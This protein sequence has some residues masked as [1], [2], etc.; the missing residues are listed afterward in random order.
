MAAATAI[1]Y[2]TTAAANFYLAY[3]R[4]AQNVCNTL[5]ATSTCPALAKTGAGWEQSGIPPGS[6]RN[7]TAT[8]LEHP[9]NNLQ[10]LK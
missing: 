10:T 3:P 8:S 1:S 5:P 4:P 7:N 9:W 2:G 6:L